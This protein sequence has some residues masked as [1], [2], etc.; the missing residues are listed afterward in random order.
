MRKLILVATVLFGIA[1]SA[2]HFERKGGDEKEQ[3]TPEQR[4]E[5]HVK[6]LTLELD[7]NDNQQKE[8]EKLLLADCKKREQ[9]KEVVKARKE[10]GKKPTKDERF[11][12]QNQRLDNEIAMKREMKKILTPE[13][14]E[15]FEKIKM[16]RKEEIKER[17]P[18]KRMK[19][20]R[21]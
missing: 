6:R 15:K 20:R 9:F 12:M 18:R 5:L 13:Q 1:A 8:V 4:T 7:L 19:H 17:K 14:Y 2:Q 11:A 3:L 21:E 10:E 16:E